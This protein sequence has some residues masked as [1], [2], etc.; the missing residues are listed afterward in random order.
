[1]VAY[2]FS[3]SVVVVTGGARG[4]GRSHALAFADA[5]ADVA[6]LDVRTD[7]ASAV[8]DAIEERGRRALAVPCDVTDEAAVEAAV[9]TVLAE[10]GRID[11]LVNNAGV[12][13]MGRLTDLDEETWDLVHDVNLKGTWL[14][15]K[16]VGRHM[17]D[18][19]GGGAIVN[20]SSF[21]GHAT[22]PGLG[23]Y[24]AS[25][26]GVRALTRTL[27]L[28]LADDGVTVNVVS[29]IGV[30]TEAVAERPEDSEDFLAA[31][32]EHAGRYNELAPGTRIEPRDVTEA[33]LWLASDAS[34]FVTGV[35]IPIDAGGLAA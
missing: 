16:H 13:R 35:A 30:K 1:M 25:K 27:S 11:V 18:R 29:P 6:V 8:V 10:L 28:E 21:F 31:G 5:G 15:A 32:T 34:R 14:V 20:T 9:D 12:D 7:S 22:V 33:V 26:F 3:D 4:I 23:A 17:T 24:S 19:D 2:D